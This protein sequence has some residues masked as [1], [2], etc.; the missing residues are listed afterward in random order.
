MTYI[1]K[2]VRVKQILLYFNLEQ[3]I[4]EREMSIV[5]NFHCMLSAQAVI[6][7]QKRGA[8]AGFTM[9][10]HICLVFSSESVLND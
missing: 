8:G 3:L 6:R 4:L 9:T 1:H 7:R 2:N 5:L 10:V